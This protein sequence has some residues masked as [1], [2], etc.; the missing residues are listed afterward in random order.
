MV[1]HRTTL[2]DVAKETGTSVSTVSLAL[3]GSPRISEA[4]TRRVQAAAARLHYH[5]DFAG[6]LLSTSKP[7]VLAMLCVAGRALHA[8]YGC[9]LARE[10]E[11]RGYRLFTEYV[12]SAQAAPHALASL[13]Q[14]RAQALIVFDPDTL[15]EIDPESVSIPMVTFGHQPANKTGDLVTCDRDSGMDQICSHLRDLGHKSVYYLAA[16]KKINGKE[17]RIAIES[18]AKQMGI[19]VTFVSSGGTIDDGFNTV[20]RLRASGDLDRQG[21][22][23]AFVCFNDDCAVGVISCLR[24]L[25]MSVPEQFSVI[26]FENSG[27]A[28]MDAFD[29]TSVGPNPHEV[30]AAIIDLAIRRAEGDESDP[31]TIYQPTTLV[32]RGSTGPA[33]R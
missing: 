32:Q 24:K 17:R 29:L 23:T 18:K 16:D 7:K 2:S 33:A 5:S 8:A 15:Q 6:S 28:T 19:S 9:A 27:F 1:A 21:G 30:A 3:R 13:Q 22:P 20:R 11:A 25:G 14:M 4:T 10:A 31:Q 12:D 26:G